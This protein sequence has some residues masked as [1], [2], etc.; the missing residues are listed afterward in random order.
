MTNRTS[1][2]ERLIGYY[3]GHMATHL[4]R[5]GVDSGLFAGLA[6]HAEGIGAEALAE[7]L[8]FEAHY[9]KHFLLSAFALELLDRDADTAQYRFAPHTKVLLAQP[10][11]YKY[12]GS[13]A[14]LYILA[15]Q[16][17]SRMPELLRTGGRYTFPQHEEELIDAVAN[18]SGGIAQFLT[19]AIVPRLPG[20]RGR[21]DVAILDL[22]CGEGS[23]VI[24]LAR[25]FPR[26]RVTGI[27]VEPHSVERANARIRAAGLEGR[28]EVLLGAAE[29]VDGAG[30]YDL[31]TMIQVL[32][33]TDPEVRD[34]ILAR[35]RAALRPGG[36]LVI[37][38]DP[39]PHEP[40]A[41]REAPVAV[42]T[43]FVEAFWG[44]V[45]LSPEDQ[46]QLVEDAGFEI[47]S[48][49][50]PPPGLMCVTVAQRG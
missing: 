21:D 26:G 1:Q 2:M 20:M 3:V 36:L 18:A 40:S 28:A 27:D 48:Q 19:R 50:V 15:G 14:H 38:D 5:L 47:L 31:V 9:V 29:K 13:M 37:V 42:L 4:I 10:E 49:M 6:A 12:M 32:H 17:F 24:A 23:A 45:L 30:A 44:S 34:T 7:Q 41:L 8:G 43:Q 35:A 11:S 33:E 25:A 46:K 16:D 39:Y 22:G